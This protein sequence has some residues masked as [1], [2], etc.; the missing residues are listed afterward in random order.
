M[1]RIKFID[2]K[3]LITE[4]VTMI[5]KALKK[6][7]VTHGFIQIPSKNTAELMGSEAT[8]FDTKLNDSPAKVDKYGRLWSEYLKNRFPVNTEVTLSR[9]ESGFQVTANGQEEEEVIAAPENMQPTEAES[10]STSVPS[11]NG[12]WYEVLEGDCIKYLNEG[13]VGNV[14]LTFFDPPYLQGKEYRFFDDSQSIVKYWNWVR[15]IVEGVYKTTSDGGALY[16]MHREKNAERILR[17]LRKTGW[18]FQNLI[19]WKKK[20]SAVPIETRFSKQYQIIAYAIK[21]KKPRV[22][23]KVRIDPPPLPEHKYQ[24]ENGV[25]LTD[26]WD[27]IRELTS[28]YFAGDEAFRDREGTRT[29]IQQTPVSLLLRIILS[30]TLPGDIVFDPTAGTGTALVVAK[31]LS[32]NSVG[33]EIDPAHVELIKKRLKTLRAADDVSCHYDYYRFTP[34]L[35]SIWKS[36]KAV[37]AEQRKLL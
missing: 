32:R 4:W 2:K 22:F 30:S 26:V 1:N 5:T 10:L 15:A 37:V 8:P 31:Q 36:E 34:N 35:K 9:N 23:N 17:I 28:G 24:H 13:A 18:N 12:T 14:H 3:T 7:E 29:H 21:G 19:I 11:A 25:Y 27:D 6:M 20:T 16:F 33:I